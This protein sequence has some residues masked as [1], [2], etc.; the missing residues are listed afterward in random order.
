[1]GAVRESKS[2]CYSPML[3]VPKGHGRGLQLCID[4]RVFN[5]I[6]IPNR[7]PLPNMDELKERVRV[8]KY[9]NK[10]DLKNGYHLIRIKEGTN[11]RQRSIAVTAFSNT[12][13]CRSDSVMHQRHSKV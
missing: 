1:M 6:T 10:I 11:G 8:A 13:S 3:F 9:F 12:L 2:A 4:Y 5:K 7:Y